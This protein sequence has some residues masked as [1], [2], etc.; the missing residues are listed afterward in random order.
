[1]PR[2][3]CQISCQCGTCGTQ[4]RVYPS[5]IKR[6]EGKYCSDP[7]Y[8]K[9]LPGRPRGQTTKIPCVCKQCH[10]SFLQYRSEI[11]KGGGRYCSETCRRQDKK[12]T[13]EKFWAKTHQEPNGCWTWTGTRSPDGYGL[14]RGPKR[15]QIR[16]HR[17]A[18]ELTLGPIPDGLFVCH[19]CDNPPCCNP[20]HF[21]L[22]THQENQ[23]DRIAKGRSSHGER[24]HFSKLRV[25]QVAEIR[26]RY[27]AG[28]TSHSVLARDYGVSPSLIGFIVTRKIWK[29]V[30]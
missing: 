20:A 12:L 30:P 27:A 9:A 24:V 7:C 19:K 11:S 21:F 18:Y 13:A 17:F 14:V 16:A 29:Q 15:T 3:S 1:M 26:A 22:G 8:R 23:A 28:G 25:S 10:A 6:G 5:A 4:F 2:T